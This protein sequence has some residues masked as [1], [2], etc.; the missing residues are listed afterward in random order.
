MVSCDCVGIGIGVG[1]GGIVGKYDAT[2][3]I[4]RPCMVGAGGK[5]EAGRGSPAP[6]VGGT[7]LEA[8]GR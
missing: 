2:G 5:H 6:G 8:T 4:P 3:G 7:V 1:V